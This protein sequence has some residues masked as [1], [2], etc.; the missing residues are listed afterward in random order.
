MAIR[1]KLHAGELIRDMRE[2]SGKTRAQAAALLTTTTSRIGQ[3]EGQADIRLST[4]AD[5]ANAL[6]YEI[7]IRKTQK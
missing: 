7:T 2:R 1:K 4:L 5:I 6:G 3:I